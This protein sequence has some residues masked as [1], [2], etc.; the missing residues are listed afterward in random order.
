MPMIIKIGSVFESKAMLKPNFVVS[1]SKTSVLK[2]STLFGLACFL[3][4]IDN[5]ISQWLV[6]VG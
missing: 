4:I 5:Q 3:L 1:Q 6:I 2:I